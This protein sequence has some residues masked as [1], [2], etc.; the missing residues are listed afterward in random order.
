MTLEEGRSSPCSTEPESQECVKM[1]VPDNFLMD[2]R[3]EIH[4]LMRANPFAVLVSHSADTGLLATH[5]PTVFKPDA[6]SQGTIEAHFARPNT[7]WRAFKDDGAEALLIFSGANGY[8]HPG[9]YP[10][11]AK[12]GKVVPTWNY[13][14]VHVYGHCRVITD[15]EQLRA[16]VAELSDQQEHGRAVPWALSD[17]PEDYVQVMLR[18]IVGI[19]VEVSRIEGKKKLSQNRPEADRRGVVTGLRLDGG[20]QDLIMADLVEQEAGDA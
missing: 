12:D 16:H 11:K 19:Q 15:A 4:N 6:G 7:H 2:D 17:A 13:S 18:G 3:D 8:I 20:E 1:Y 5:L 14:A 9:W 10:T